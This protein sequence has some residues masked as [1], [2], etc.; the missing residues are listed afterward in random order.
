MGWLHFCRWL[1]GAGCPQGLSMQG[2][3]LGWHCLLLTLC[4]CLSLNKARWCLLSQTAAW[5]GNPLKWAM[6]H[7]SRN[8]WEFVEMTL[9]PGFTLTPSSPGTLGLG[10]Q[11]LVVW[12]LEIV[13]WC[14][15]K[16]TPRITSHFSHLQLFFYCLIN[17]TSRAHV[18]N[19]NVNQPLAFML[20]GMIDS[21]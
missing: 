21:Q 13:K 2:A 12:R 9:W 11:L 8:A 14:P 20:N 15:L 7:R 17:V 6:I 5:S 18:R 1:S 10:G 3:F 4:L 19:K 16:E